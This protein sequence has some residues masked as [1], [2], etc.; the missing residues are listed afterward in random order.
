MATGSGCGGA[1]A[2]VLS[3]PFCSTITSSTLGT[4]SIASCRP[5]AV[6]SA[7]I[8]NAASTPACR[9]RDASAAQL[10]THRDRRARI[11]LQTDRWTVASEFVLYCP[12]A[13]GPIMAEPVT[14]MLD[15][16]GPIGSRCAAFERVA[17]EPVT[18]QRVAPH[19]VAPRPVATGPIMTRSAVS[20]R[21]TCGLVGPRPGSST[22]NPSPDRVMGVGPP[23]G[24]CLAPNARSRRLV[25]PANRT[26]R[27]LG[28]ST[29]TPCCF[30]LASGSTWIVISRLLISAFSVASIRSQMAC[31]S[32]TVIVPGTTR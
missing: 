31:E 2:A 6:R 24:E 17:S 9:T 3:C 12:V 20:W 32:A 5:R 13:L 29:S 11:T 28:Y 1:C 14:P 21:E 4:A 10:R 25:I 15:T 8:R 16:P 7:R 26:C 27:S 22:G 18:P 23:A 30:A 19:P